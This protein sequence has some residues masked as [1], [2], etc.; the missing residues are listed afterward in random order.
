MA[1]VAGTVRNAATTDVIVEKSIV[2][3]YLLRFEGIMKV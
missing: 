3:C 1:A 2:I